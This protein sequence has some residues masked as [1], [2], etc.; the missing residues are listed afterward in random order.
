LGTDKLSKVKPGTVPDHAM[1]DVTLLTEM[2]SVCIPAM[3]IVQEEAATFGME[4]NWSKTKIQAVGTQHFRSVV[5]RAP[6]ARH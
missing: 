3:E 1:Y 5:H 2:L 6:A 4:I